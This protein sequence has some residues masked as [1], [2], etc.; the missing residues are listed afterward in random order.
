MSEEL[1]KAEIKLSESAFKNLQKWLL[2]EKYRDFTAEILDLIKNEDWV[3][4]EDAFFKI[5]ELGTAG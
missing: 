5:L 4:L 2:D 1:V 3:E